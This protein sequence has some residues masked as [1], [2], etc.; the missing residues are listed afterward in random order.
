MGF[1]EGQYEDEAWG[2]PGVIGIL[3]AVIIIAIIVAVGAWLD[4]LDP[5]GKAAAVVAGSR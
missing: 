3:A 1:D 2:D 5:V 4:G